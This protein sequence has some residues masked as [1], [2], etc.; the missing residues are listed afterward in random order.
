MLHM[1]E[2]KLKKDF[3]RDKKAF[4]PYLNKF[5]K[6]VFDRCG[7]ERSAKGVIT[8]LTDSF[9]VLKT[10]KFHYTHHYTKIRCVFIMENENLYK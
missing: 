4:E 3:T 1:K 6:I 8:S 9:L 2:Q 10:L 7:E 5:V